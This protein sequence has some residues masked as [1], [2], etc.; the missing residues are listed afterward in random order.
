MADET[1]ELKAPKDKGPEA[2]KLEIYDGA[3][4]QTITVD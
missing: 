2:G 1:V 4:W 3:A